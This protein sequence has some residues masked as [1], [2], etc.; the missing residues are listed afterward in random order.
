MSFSIQKLVPLLCLWYLCFVKFSFAQEDG[1][2][3]SIL[4][5]G[6]SLSYF[7]NLP[8]LV[9]LEAQANGIT[10]RTTTLAYPNYAIED[11]WHDG[12]VQELIQSKRFTFV[13]I[14]QGPSSQ[15]AGR[16]M[17][18]DYGK[19]YKELCDKNNAALVYFMVW[20]SLQYF[21]TFDGVIK[22]YT[23]AAAINAAI[24]CPVGV[25]WQKYINTTAQL[26]YYSSDGFHPSK[27][28][29]AATAKTI[30]KCL[31]PQ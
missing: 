31:F 2:P 20:P 18:I 15:I 23:D 25:E 30:V 7:N 12:K 10:L 3:I 5:V 24:L 16:T 1:S 6:N 14:Q 19:K 8:E 4:F 17:L 22:N 13:V 26:D 9:R 28:G 29:S 11:H 21:H 27:K